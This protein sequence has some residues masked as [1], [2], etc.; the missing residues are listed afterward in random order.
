MKEE[1]L[2]PIIN[3]LIS[4][5]GLAGAIEYISTGDYPKDIKNLSIDIINGTRNHKTA[6]AEHGDISDIS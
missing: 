2:R 5:K 1:D 3:K 4:E 6:M